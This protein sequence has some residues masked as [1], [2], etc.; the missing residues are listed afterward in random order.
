VSR[1]AAAAGLLAC[2][3]MLGAAEPG[4]AS[5][6]DATL[7]GPLAGSPWYD[8]GA[9]TWRRVVPAADPPP[10]EYRGEVA[11]TPW[12]GYA[13]YA[14]VAIAIGLL[15]HQ[16]WRLRGAWGEL[17]A[18]P[19][20]RTKA[21]VSALPFALPNG[22][23]DPEDALNAALAAQD[24][25]RAVIWLY[26]LQLI[27]LDAVGV[28]RLVPGKTNRAYLG[29]AGSALPRAAGP[30]AETIAVF[31]RSH[32]G[33]QPAGRGEVEALLA[34]HRVLLAALPAAEA[35]P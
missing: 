18:A 22:A 21:A 13:M 9:D 29:E 2:L 31:E 16:V 1:R 6:G 17:D 35:G 7:A 27:R 15:V 8:P 14:A 26:A 23:E 20:P 4:P 28:V 10:L 3:A 33:H 5:G 34:G 24:H 32:F 11:G 30:L 25:P 19:R 12:F